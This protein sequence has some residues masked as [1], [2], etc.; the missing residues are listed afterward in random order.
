[1]NRRQILLAARSLQGH[2]S[3]ATPENQQAD[4]IYITKLMLEA[5]KLRWRRRPVIRELAA[6]EAGLISELRAEHQD[7][8]MARRP[9]RRLFLK[10]QASAR[11]DAHRTAAEE[12]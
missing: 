3:T 12:E 5:E 8:P 9:Q 7:R 11:R 4:L 2:S 1:M 10:Q 6:V